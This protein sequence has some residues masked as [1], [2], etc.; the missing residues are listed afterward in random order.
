ME[1]N[2]E[3]GARE[4]SKWDSGDSKLNG[5]GA[6]RGGRVGNDRSRGGRGGGNSRISEIT[7]T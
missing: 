5:S 2:V 1:R 6:E 7:R 3:E 4:D